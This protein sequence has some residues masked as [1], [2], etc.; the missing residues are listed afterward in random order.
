MKM[1]WH[2]APG[3]NI[4]KGKYMSSYFAQKKQVV[5]TIVKYNLPVIPLVI[6]MIYAATFEIH[7]LNFYVFCLDIQS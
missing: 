2:Q 6:N 5:F 1:I 7:I 3:Q 4:S